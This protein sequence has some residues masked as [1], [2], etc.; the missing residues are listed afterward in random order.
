MIDSG[1]EIYNNN[2]NNNNL[3][4]IIITEKYINDINDIINNKDI[5]KSI[6]YKDSTASVIQHMSRILGYNNIDFIKITNLDSKD[7]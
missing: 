5:R 1:I 6:V 2:N 3:E 4:E 7:T